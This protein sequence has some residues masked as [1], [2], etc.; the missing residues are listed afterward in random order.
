MRLSSILLLSA[1][2]LI[3]VISA[4]NGFEYRAIDDQQMLARY[5]KQAQ[6][7]YENPTDNNRACKPLYAH[8]HEITPLAQLF[9]RM[10]QENIVGGGSVDSESVDILIKDDPG[11]FNILMHLQITLDNG[12][13]GSFELYQVTY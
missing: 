1:V 6:G 11:E 3:S 7:F 5:M 13:C 4:D 2:I 10:S 9:L 12:E 8:D